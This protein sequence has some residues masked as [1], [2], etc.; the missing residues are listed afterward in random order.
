MRK[1]AWLCLSFTAAIAVCRYLL[2]GRLLVPAILGCALCALPG[3]LLRGKWRL[4]VLLAA[5]GAGLGCLCFWGQ[6]RFV[7]RPAEQHVGEQVAVSARVTDWPDVYDGREY[8][9]VRLT[10]PGL[11]RV[12]CRV[13]SYEPGELAGLEPGD[14]IAGEVRFASALVRSGEEVDTYISRGIYLRAVCTDTPEVTGRWGASA[15]YLPLRLAHWVKEQCRGVFPEDTVSFMTALLTGDKSALY[16]DG[17]RYYALS[18]AGLAHVVAVSGMHIAYLMGFVFLLTGR[19]RWAV[20]ASYPLLLFFAAMTGFTPSVTR[21]VFMQMCIFSAA[22]FRREEDALTSLSVILALILLW[23]PAAIG[24]VSLQLSFASMAGIWLLGDRMYRA[25]WGR[26]EERL[27]QRF[28]FLRPFAAFLA[29]VFSMSVSAQI[30]TAPLCAI[31][32][33]YLSTVSPVSGILCLWM[34]SGLYI[35]GYLTVILGAVLPGAAGLAGHVLAWGVRYIFFVSDKLALIPCESV[36]MTN[37]LFV[38]WLV[39]VYVLFLTAWLSSRR[40]G[41]FRPAA[42]I[43]LALISLYASALSVRLSWSSELRVTALDVGQG[44][45]VV[46]TCG[47][48]AVVVD[49]GG[50]YLTDD[51]GAAAVSFLGGQQRRHVD[52][53]I[54]THL[55]SDHVNGAARLMTQLDVDTLYLPLQED[56]D[57]YLGQILHAAVD[58]GT[59]IRYVTENLCLTVGEMELTL[60]APM[61]SGAENEN[62]LMILAARNGFEALI[63]GDSLAEA[64]ELLVSRY[65]LPDAEVLVAGHHGSKTSTCARLLEE[66]RPDV[67]LISVG[68]NTYGHPHREVLDRLASYGVTVLR[69]DREGNITIKPER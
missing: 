29:A 1:A 2:P 57:G 5:L 65:E 23:N 68:N 35:G 39:F 66:L 14:E 16:R 38:I 62:C 48:R 33:G 50:S 6:Q 40:S 45:S 55:H 17:D 60:W 54:L 36:Y 53:L 22:F 44:E 56:E 13:A 42:P 21:A 26:L 3:L 63:T 52:A 4:C 32:F 8:V 51:A 59:R 34:V 30:L 27:S 10:A 61:L 19:R 41:R 69:T 24:G 28:R 9:T 67:A 7:I 64:E 18:E 31:H 49:C 58:N 12:R 11:P 46:L 15:L 47:P 20:L 25:L 43:C 37:P